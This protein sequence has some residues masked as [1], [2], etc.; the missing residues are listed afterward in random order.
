MVAVLWPLFK[1]HVH[2]AYT[3]Q[4]LAVLWPFLYF[5]LTV[6]I[7]H[8]TKLQM[9]A[10]LWLHLE[11]W[12]SCHK[13]A[14]RGSSMATFRSLEKVS[15]QIPTFTVLWTQHPD[16]LSVKSGFKIAKVCSFNAVSIK[17]P[18]LAVVWTHFTNS[19]KWS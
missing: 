9:V 10:V 13:T 18:E 5:C 19:E 15:I 16:F 3:N 17:L 8:D 11:L 4:T 1:V 14:N 7:L 2:S 6:R 12:K